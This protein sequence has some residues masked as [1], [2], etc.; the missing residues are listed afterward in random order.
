MAE[1]KQDIYAQSGR[2]NPAGNAMAMAPEQ[3]FP[4]GIYC[5]AIYVGGAG[6]LAVEMAQ[7]HSTVIFPNVAAGMYYPIRAAKILAAGTTAS[8][9]VIMW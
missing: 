2:M 1:E 6:D 5:R 7:D 3:E 9:L 8:N 4:D